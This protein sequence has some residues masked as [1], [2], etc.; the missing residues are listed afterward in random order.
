[1]VFGLVG[2]PGGVVEVEPDPCAGFVA[3]LLLES[4]GVVECGA[5][6][7]GEVVAAGVVAGEDEGVEDGFGVAGLGGLGGAG[8]IVFVEGLHVI[9]ESDALDDVVEH[10]ALGSGERGVV[11]RAQRGAGEGV[12]D[13]G[14]A[15]DADG[16]VIALGAWPTL[17]PEFARVEIVCGGGGVPR[18]GW[19]GV[20]AAGEDCCSDDCGGKRDAD[21]VA[22]DVHVSEV[23]GMT[24]SQ[25]MRFF[26]LR[27]G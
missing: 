24:V 8:G 1:M 4:P 23:L 6:D 22:V 16:S 5:S 7:V 3:G 13:Y 26:L 14:V 25:S 27:G 19:G 20:C 12:G 17:P 2:L 21:G 9:P 18:G 11:M 15:G 10:Y